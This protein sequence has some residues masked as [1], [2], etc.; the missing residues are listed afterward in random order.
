MKS[1]R[2]VPARQT[3]GKR[4]HPRQVPGKSVRSR[5]APRQ[6]PERAE[7]TD[8]DQ[9]ARWYDALVGQEGSD[10]QKDIIMPGVHRLLGLKK[11]DRVLDLA[12]G[13][14]VFSRFLSQKGLKVIGLD[15]SEALIRHARS[16]STDATK[17]MCSDAGDNEA[18]AGEKFSGIA[19]LMA[20]Q[21]M[22]NIQPVFENIARWL[23]PGGRFVLVTTHP[24]FRIP[25]Q[26]HWGWDEDKKMEYRRMDLYASETAIPIFTPPMRTEGPHTWTYH[27]P[28]ASY[29]SALN[30]AGLA[31]VDLEE[32][33][34]N[35]S[36]QPGKRA[37]AENRARREFPIFLTLVATPLKEG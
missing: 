14:G 25:R 5:S 19:C 7:L 30:K 34:S 17:F 9:A 26:S 11:G 15:A 3:A 28:L 24:C 2:K 27:R 10:F 21:N 6:A 37:K 16:R 12:C 1:R 33:T 4:A 13:Q 22:E 29:F 31:V 23:T 35:K 20:V 36:S 8:W 32:W 18:L